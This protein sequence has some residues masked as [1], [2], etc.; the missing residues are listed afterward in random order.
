VVV[1]VTFPDFLDGVV[2]TPAPEPDPVVPDFHAGAEQQERPSLFQRSN[3]RT[4]R[5]KERPTRTQKPE[6][7][8]PP[9][10]PGK[11]RDAMLETYGAFAFFV[12]PF[13]PN[14]A[15]TIMSPVKPATE[16]TPNP[17]TVAENC[18]DAWEAAAKQYPWVRKMLEG[19]IGFAVITG[20]VLAHA[21]IF[22]AVVEGTSLAEKLNPAAA[23][24]AM[25]RKQAE[26]TTE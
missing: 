7:P 2:P 10:Q 21:P 1:L 18:A 13:K 4:T 24:E 5:T 12:M 11:V 25:L 26:A 8:A 16:E 3:G 15:I 17:P 6:K 22:S 9:Y 19:G 20:L 23:M 14:V